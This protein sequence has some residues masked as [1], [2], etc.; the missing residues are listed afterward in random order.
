[1]AK[2]QWNGFFSSRP[3]AVTYT[4]AVS[5][6]LP[7]KMQFDKNKKKLPTPYGLFC[8]WAKN[9]L[10]GDWASTT[11]SGVGFAISV[12]SQ[13]DSALI[14]STFGASAQPQSTE[15]GNTTFQC[16]YSDSRYASLAK[17]LGYVL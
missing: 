8:E 9:N 7:K 11:I 17:S 13:D 5:A 6:T 2:K 16:G 3:N 12:E 15:V 4:S 1:M 14:T 10:T